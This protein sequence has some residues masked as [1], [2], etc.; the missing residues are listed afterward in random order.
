MVCPAGRQPPAHRLH[1]HRG[2]HQ[3]VPVPSQ[4]VCMRPVVAGRIERVE[5]P[6]T[7][8]SG[9][10]VSLR[11]VTPG[12]DLIDRVGTGRLMTPATLTPGAMVRLQRLAGNA[13][14]ASMVAGSRARRAAAAARSAA[15]MGMPG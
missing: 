15:P 5:M 2:D 1:Y 10:A 13:R 8:P 11:D 3:D 9:E 14:V 4:G 6:R 12:H 7:R